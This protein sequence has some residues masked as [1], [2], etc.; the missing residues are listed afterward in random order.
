MSKIRQFRTSDGYYLYDPGLLNAFQPTLLGRPV[1]ENPAMA[2]VASASKSVAY[3]DFSQYVIRQLPLR[4]DV[5]S[6]YGWGSDQMAI[7]II[8]EGDGDL[9]HATAIRTLVS[10]DT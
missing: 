2:A 8:Y 9:M 3:G 7:R 6:E 4:V 10:D 1:L 5:S